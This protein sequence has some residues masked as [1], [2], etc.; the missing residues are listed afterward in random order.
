VRKGEEE[1][2]EEEEEGAESS[3]LRQLATIMHTINNLV[4][5]RSM[6]VMVQSMLHQRRRGSF[7]QGWVPSFFTHFTIQSPCHRF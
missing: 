1:E 6:A 3:R 7:L 5:G 2:E 4:A